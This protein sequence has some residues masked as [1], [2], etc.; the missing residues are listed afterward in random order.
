MKRHGKR[1]LFQHL[2]LWGS[3]VVYTLSLPHVITVYNAILDKTSNALVGRIPVIILIV[4]CAV[5]ILVLLQIRKEPKRLLLLIPCVAIVLAVIYLESNPNKHIHIPQYI[6]MSWIL[7]AAL[8]IDYHGGG[9][10]LLTL[11]CA[12]LLG[13]V[14]EILQGIHPARTYGWS[15]M[16]VNATASIVGV[17]SIKAIVGNRG[18]GWEW[19]Q[20]FRKNGLILALFITGATGA[21]VMLVFLFNA[22]EPDELRK[23]YPTW[24]LVWNFLFLFLTLQLGTARWI[25]AKRKGRSLIDEHRRRN[26]AAITADVWVL[27]PLIILFC[28]HGLVVSVIL[29]DIPFS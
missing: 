7:F 13:I 23:N 21:S 8:S 12:S 16:L 3:V 28:M 24:M 22:G 4:L 17:I 1:L 15:D 19:R 14:D 26:P 11:V 2:L 20:Y 6:L 5:H 9:I 25:K 10:L 18:S 27:V 29:M